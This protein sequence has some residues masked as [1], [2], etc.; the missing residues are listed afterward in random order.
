MTRIERDTPLDE[1]L[2]LA[3]PAN[4]RPPFC[5]SCGNRVLPGQLHGASEWL[6]RSQSR[7]PALVYHWEHRPLNALERPRRFSGMTA[8]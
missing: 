6:D 3:N 5:C 8:P 2:A 7:H 4:R 1:A